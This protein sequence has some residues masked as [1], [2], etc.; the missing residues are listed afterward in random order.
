VPSSQTQAAAVAANVFAEFGIERAPPLHYLE[1][2]LVV[3]MHYCT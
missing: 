2:W 3:E 1:E